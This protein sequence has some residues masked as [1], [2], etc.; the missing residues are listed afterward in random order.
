MA[1]FPYIRFWFRDY[2]TDTRHLT[3]TEHG[4][5]L[6]LLL[7][8]WNT[9]TCSLPD[10]D[11]LLRRCA[12]SPRNWQA[13]KPNVMAYWDLGNGR[14]T[15]KRLLLERDWVTQ[16]ASGQARKAKAKHLKYNNTDSARAEPG[17]CQPIPEPYKREEGTRIPDG[18]KPSP[19]TYQWAM[20]K[21]ISNQELD[22]AAE[23]LLHEKKADATQFAIKIDWQA[24]LRAKILRDQQKRKSNGNGNGH[25]RASSGP[26]HPAEGVRRLRARLQRGAGAGESGAAIELLPKPEGK[27]S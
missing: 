24:A 8:A 6:L 18:F 15:Q 22:E 20:L 17:V 9:P 3:T 13:I 27:R 11:T 2:L 23:L 1:D 7:S 21:G 14:W 25:Q 5:Y 19:E 26:A 10:D 16:Y 12:G 4:A